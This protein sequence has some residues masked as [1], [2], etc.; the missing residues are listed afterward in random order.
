SATLNAGNLDDVKKVMGDA[1][2]NA[3]VLEKAPPLAPY[4]LVL[5]ADMPT[6]N[7][8]VVFMALPYAE[9]AEAEAAA[10]VVANRLRQWQPYKAARPLVDEVVGKVESK[11]VGDAGVGAAVSRTFVSLVTSVGDAP[12]AKLIAPRAAG[13]E[14]GAV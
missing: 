1:E 13:S 5:L 12:W 8:H 11:V 3:P 9:R 6:G 7:E 10:G 14:G 2:K 4:P